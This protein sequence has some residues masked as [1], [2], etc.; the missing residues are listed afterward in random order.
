MAQPTISEALQKTKGRGLAWKDTDWIEDMQPHSDLQNGVTEMAL[1]GEALK[2]LA[3][4]AVALDNAEHGT[5]EAMKDDFCQRFNLSKALLGRELQKLRDTGR[6]QRS[7]AGKTELSKQ[8]AMYIS[9]HIMEG[10]RKND[11][12]NISI[13]EAVDVLRTNNKIVAGRTDKET[14]EHTPYSESAIATALRNYC[15]HPD[16]LRQQSPATP[17]RSK[18]PNDVW[19]LDASVCIIFYLQDGNY[20]MCELDKAMHYKNKPENLG[21]IEKYRVIRYVLTDHTSGFI[22]WR[23]YKHSESGEHSVHFL[24]WCMAEKPLKNYLFQGKPNVLV[25]DPGATSSG[26]V[27]RFCKRMD[28]RLLKNKPRNPRAKGSVER[29]NGIVEQV[30]E[31]KLRAFKAKPENFDQLNDLALRYQLFFNSTEIHSR[32]KKTRMDVWMMIKQEQLIK[33]PSLEILLSLA[34][35]SPKECT[36]R[37]GDKAQLYVQFKAK[38]YNV[39]DVPGVYVKAKIQVSWHPFIVNHAAAIVIDEDGYESYIALPEI[40]FDEFGFSEQGAFY[41]DEYKSIPDTVADKNRKLINELSTGTKNQDDA[42]KKRRE[43]G[44]TPFNGE[45]NPFLKMETT[46]LPEF[47]QKRGTEMDLNLPSIDLPKLNHVQFAKYGKSKMGDN[48]NSDLYVQ[49]KKHFPNGATEPELDQW[50]VECETQEQRP[51]L[52]RV[53]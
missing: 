35:E 14:G 6:K 50:L 52:R 17:M 48:W 11:K 12:K 21:A 46:Q 24:A 19:Q 42:D 49:I 15:L 3:F 16:Q 29:A 37:T 43:K 13:K 25:V 44:F 32:T 41:G 34:T 39:K 30:F 28:I 18:H 27:G 40:T 36:V 7:D 20:G 38:F 26:L 51:T 10:Y 23:Y 1:S 47:I 53:V 5:K 8:E 31:Q 2:Q 22:A 9:A 33:T 4:L 45:V